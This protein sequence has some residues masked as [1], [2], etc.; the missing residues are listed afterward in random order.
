MPFYERIDADKEKLQELLNEYV[1][2]CNISKLNIKVENNYLISE[3]DI[4]N[5]HLEFHMEYNKYNQQ[6]SH[7]EFY[8]NNKHRSPFIVGAQTYTLEEC[9]SQLTDLIQKIHYNNSKTDITSLA[10]PTRGNIPYL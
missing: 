10:T 1:K 9:V 4:N 8:V 2:P 3:M 6:Y 5:N 7:I